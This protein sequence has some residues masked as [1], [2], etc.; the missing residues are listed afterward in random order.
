MLGDPDAD[1]LPLSESDVTALV[2][3]LTDANGLYETKGE[4]EGGGGAEA[5]GELAALPG[6]GD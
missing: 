3:G 1:T 4:A 2:D 6:P 5:A